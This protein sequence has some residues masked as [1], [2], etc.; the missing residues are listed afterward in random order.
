MARSHKPRFG[1]CCKFWKDTMR[2]S[3]SQK[4][5]WSTRKRI[6]TQRRRRREAAEFRAGLEG[7]EELRDELETLDAEPGVA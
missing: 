7:E 3:R 6:E 4:R 2:A 1:M 5:T